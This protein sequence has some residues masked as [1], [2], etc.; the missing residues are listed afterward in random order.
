MADNRPRILAGK[1]V[2]VG[3]GAPCNPRNEV[4]S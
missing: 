2:Q 4:C 1:G 3:P